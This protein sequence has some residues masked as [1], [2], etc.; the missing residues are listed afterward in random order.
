LSVKSLITTERKYLTAKLFA[1]WLMIVLWLGTF[2]LSASPQLHFLLHQDA[3]SP[4]HQC[5]ITQIQQQLFVSGLAAI[6]VPAP[7]SVFSRVSSWVRSEFV[8]SFDFR[9]A[10]SRGPPVS[11][12]SSRA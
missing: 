10:L 6:S 5:L 7:S 9:V 3:N 8:P 2:A 11:G 1:V 4:Q 12:F